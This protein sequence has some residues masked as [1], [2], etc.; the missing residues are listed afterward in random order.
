MNVCKQWV[1]NKNVVPLSLSLN[2][3]KCNLQVSMV[4]RGLKLEDSTGYFMT[5]K[6]VKSLLK[7]K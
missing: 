1:H 5:S 3:Y 7:T 6:I 2:Y 4:F